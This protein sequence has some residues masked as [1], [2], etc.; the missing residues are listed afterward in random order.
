[1]PTNH[2]K[3]IRY[4]S[5]FENSYSRLACAL[6]ERLVRL[7]LGLSARKKGTG[8]RPT[9]TLPEI[10]GTVRGR[11][12]VPFFRPRAQFALARHRAAPP[13]VLAPGFI[14]PA[15]RP[16]IRAVFVPVY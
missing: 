5:R 8:T 7:T 3:S 15:E 13:S 10:P 16:S 1:M 6:F 12:P 11:E 14:A 4:P 2:A 9:G